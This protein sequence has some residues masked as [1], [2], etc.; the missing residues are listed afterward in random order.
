[1]WQSFVFYFTNFL[2]IHLSFCIEHLNT[3][4]TLKSEYYILYLKVILQ[5]DVSVN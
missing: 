3:K 2:Q 4:I 1:M 5:Y